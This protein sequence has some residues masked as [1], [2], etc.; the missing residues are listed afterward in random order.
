MRPVAA[1]LTGLVTVGAAFGLWLGLRAV[2]PG[3]TEMIEAAAARYVAETAGARTDC[4]GRPAGV[5][6]VR[7]VV[8]CGADWAVALDRWGRPVDALGLGPGT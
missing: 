8:T 1:L 2:P 3:E 7:L 5:P 4:A 6:G